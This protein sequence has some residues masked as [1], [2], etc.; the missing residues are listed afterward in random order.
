MRE[1]TVHGSLLVSQAFH[2]LV[3]AE[4]K[5]PPQEKRQEECA[6]IHPGAEGPED[7]ADMCP[8]TA[9]T[10]SEVSDLSEKS[11]LPKF[12]TPRS[13]RKG[14]ARRRVKNRKSAR[15]LQ[16]RMQKEVAQFLAGINKANRNQ[17]AVSAVA[18][19]HDFSSLHPTAGLPLG[20]PPGR[21]S[22][23]GCCSHAGDVEECSSMR[24]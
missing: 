12:I 21:A 4:P 20:A 13:R 1:R 11:D 5:P 2:G 3:E 6:L 14:R 23:W 9:T 22:D 19:V 10:I 18:V 24:G 17:D 16:K 15:E 7:Q 8:S